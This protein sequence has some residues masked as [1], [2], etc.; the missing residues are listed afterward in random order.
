[1]KKLWIPVLLLCLVLLSAATDEYYFKINKSFDIFGAV[2]REIQENYLIEVD[3]E[4]LMQ[5]GVEGMLDNL[6]PY[7]RFYPEEDREDIDLVTYGRYVG[8]GI[9]IRRIDGNVTVVDFSEDHHAFNQGLRIGDILYKIDGDEVINLP[10]SELKNYT[11]GEENSI[12]NIEVLRNSLQDTVKLTLRRQSVRVNDVI[13]SG[14]LDEKTGYIKLQRFSRLAVSEFKEALQNVIDDGA[15]NVIVDV[16]N[17]PGGLLEA[18]VGIAEQFLSD[19]SLIVS[20]KGRKSYKNN[21]Y[22]ALGDP[23]APKVKVAVL[24]NESSAS[25]SEILA[26]AI[27]DHDRG[28]VLGQNS[29]GKGLVQTVINLP[30]QTKLKVTT[31][32]YFTPSGRSIQRIDHENNSVFSRDT[33]VFYTDAGREVIEHI[34]ITPDTT[35]GR[36][37]Y[38]NYVRDMVN[39]ELFFKFATLLVDQNLKIDENFIVSDS[40]VNEYEKFLQS[41]SYVYRSIELNRIEDLY[42]DLYENDYSDEE[43]SFLDSLDSIVRKKDREHF[44][45]HIDQIKN[46]L[47]YEILRRKYN[48]AEL[49]K[50]DIEK[51]STVILAT[52]LLNSEKYEEI[53]S[54]KN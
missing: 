17:N 48:Q 50:F 3:P 12:A 4:I 54:P 47:R 29:F 2:Y 43:I 14:L 20:T 30:Y 49:V 52:D 22:S 34:G 42:T 46:V 1:M 33:N 44:S 28:I 24:I 39:K 38:D 25:A 16:R 35:V 31:A 18:S 6:D 36:I 41:E 21:E 23:M 10:S 51:D 45:S 9:S 7:T 19:G 5:D 32:N 53:L 26:G 27:Q 8:F 13:W 40:I 15:N 11:Q 37:V